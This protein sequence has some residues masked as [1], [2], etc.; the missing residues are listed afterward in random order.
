MGE[1]VPNEGIRMHSKAKTDVLRRLRTAE[2]HI[3]G[4]IKMVEEDAYC[5]DAIDQIQ[6]VQAALN[7]IKAQILEA[8]LHSCVI[9]AVRGDD[10]AERERILAEI[11]DVFQ[12]STK[13]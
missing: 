3:R 7:K 11:A 10:V 5:I 8:H 4:V 6:A 12:K 13:V 2:G 9:T 1:G